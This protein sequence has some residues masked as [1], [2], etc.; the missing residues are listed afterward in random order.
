M[1]ERFPGRAEDDRV[2]NEYGPQIGEAEVSYTAEGYRQTL[3]EHGSEGYR[4]VVVE[5]VTGSV[6]SDLW[7]VDE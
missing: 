3:Y 4:I 7:Y 1:D 2:E 6:I 5:P